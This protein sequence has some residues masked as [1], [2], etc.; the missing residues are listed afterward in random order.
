MSII[1]FLTNQEILKSKK[2]ISVLWTTICGI[3]SII[4]IW[5]AEFYT[6]QIFMLILLTSG[7]CGSIISAIAIDL[8]PTSIK[9]MALC[10]ILMCGRLF[11]ALGSNIIGYLLVINCD[12][13]FILV[14][15]V[16]LSKNFIC[17]S[18]TKLIS[19][20]D[21]GCSAVGLTLSNS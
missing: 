9:A 18:L 3:S 11:A 20:F 4:L 1:I 19:C 6:I 7:C 5:A 16:L 2:N 15:V 21:L 12:V 8:F 10:L 13:V 17:F 14:A